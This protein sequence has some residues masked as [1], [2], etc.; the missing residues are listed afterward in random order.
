MTLENSTGTMATTA[1]PVA[2]AV[3]APPIIS[4]NEKLFPEVVKMVRATPGG[5][6]GLLK[7]FQDKGLGHV[8]SA[9]TSRDGTRM[10]SPQQLVQGLGTLQIEALATA[11]RLDVKVVRKELVLVLPQVLEQLVAARNAGKGVTVKA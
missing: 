4:D 3:V 11:S 2:K 8:A 9:L 1:E 5:V 7:Q 6:P 10:I